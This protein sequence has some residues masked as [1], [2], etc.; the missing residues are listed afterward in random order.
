MATIDHFRTDET[1]G[2]EIAVYQSGAEMDRVTGKFV[3]APPKYAITSTNVNEYHNLRK[4]KQLAQRDAIAAGI[5]QAMKDTGFVPHAAEGQDAEQAA[6]SAI[7]NK[8]ATLLL[9]TQGARGF[10]ELAEWLFSSA[11]WV[12]DRREAQD[13]TL[14]S[15]D[16]LRGLFHELAQLVRESKNG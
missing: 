5:V 4:V 6:A 12:P 9:D 15:V 10:K 1:T 13:S 2:H 11:D 8:G 16:T 3:K 7:A 14:E